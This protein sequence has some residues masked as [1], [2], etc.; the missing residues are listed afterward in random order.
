VYK[1][2]VVRKVAQDTR[3]SQR[4]VSDALN[5]MVNVVSQALREGKTVTLPGF[6]TFYT[7]IRG[8]GT[9]KHIRTKE[10]IKVPA[11]RVAAFRVGEVLK[12]SVRNVKP[13]KRAKRSR[14]GFIRGGK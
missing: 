11:R 10:T 7:S 9:V 6:G 13:E 3:L 14:L 5:S 2:D 1:N 8:E 12:K 4:A